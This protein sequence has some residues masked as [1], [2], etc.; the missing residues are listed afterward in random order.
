M[1]LI[2]GW[3]LDPFPGSL[4]HYCPVQEVEVTVLKECYACAR[5]VDDDA[6]G[7]IEWNDG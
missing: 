3:A 6:A 2:L 7:G 4:A 5:L 1:E